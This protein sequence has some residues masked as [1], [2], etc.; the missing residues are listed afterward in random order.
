MAQW[1]KV[2]ALSLQ[3]LGSLL[4]FG[5]NPWSGN[6]HILWTWP[7]QKKQQIPSVVSKPG[8]ATEGLI[9]LLMG[10][11]GHVLTFAMIQEME[12]R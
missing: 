10:D 12:S 7:P 3:H 1:V 11:R 4:W 8:R 9:C 5:F 2:L 6:F